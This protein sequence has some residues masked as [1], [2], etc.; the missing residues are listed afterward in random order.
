MGLFDFFTINKSDEYNKNG[1]NKRGFN[2]NGQHYHTGTRFDTNG[3]DKDG[4][5]VNGFN[6]KGFNRKGIHYHT[7]TKYDTNGFT[8]SSK[9]S[10][11]YSKQ[12]YNNT[13]V[14]PQY[15]NDG[16]DKNGYNNKGFNKKGYHQHTGTKYDKD[17]FNING[18]NSNGFN[19]D[20][21]HYYYGTKYDKDGY[22]INGY[23]LDGYNK[24]GYNS[25]GFDRNG[26]KL[27]TSTEINT[28]SECNDSYTYNIS[29]SE[30]TIEDNTNDHK[31]KDIFLDID[32]SKKSL[33]IND[34]IASLSHLRRASGRMVTLLL[35]ESSI[36][37]FKFSKHTTFEKLSLIQ[38]YHL[39]DTED[40][41]LLH[42]IRQTGNEAVH[43]A[44]GD[45]D[46]TEKL[47]EQF[48][49]FIT[50]WIEVD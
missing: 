11:A 8:D 20:G 43:S 19:K 24:D 37:D 14:P 42:E 3:Y 2:R 12:E 31:L 28:F 22:D 7:G 38:R 48:E 32:L 30:I 5:N 36:P 9:S 26:T 40:L 41:N 39:I 34:Y 44:T 16:Y 33:K 25:S 13:Y 21:Y 18:F 29:Y 47:I 17:G 35:L 15:D 50:D 10:Q 45:K 1:F 4:Y 46:T 6:K 49:E 23:D 27:N